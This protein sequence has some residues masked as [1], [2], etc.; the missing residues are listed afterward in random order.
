MNVVF[1]SPP[2]GGLQV[3]LT[4]MI[5]ALR[6]AL[7]NVVVDNAASGRLMLRSATTGQVYEITVDDSGTPELVVTLN[8]GKERI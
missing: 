1:P 4:Q 8:A 6:R 7:L 2:P 3:F 5:E